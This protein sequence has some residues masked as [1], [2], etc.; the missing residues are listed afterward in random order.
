MVSSS[1]RRRFF[2]LCFDGTTSTLDDFRSSGIVSAAGNLSN[3]VP[4]ATSD[5]IVLFN[6]A[7]FSIV[8]H[9]SVTAP[10]E[11]E[12]NVRDSDA[13]LNLKVMIARKKNH[14]LEITGG[15]LDFLAR[16]RGKRLSDWWANAVTELTKA[17]FDT[18]FFEW[19]GIKSFSASLPPPGQLVK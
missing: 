1:N 17:E 15:K 11:F 13:S 16:P 5:W 9:G 2:L 12:L 8:G 14:P 6:K 7:T 19:W 4:L 18:I 10:F 3:L